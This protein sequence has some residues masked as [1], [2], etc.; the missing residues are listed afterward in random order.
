[1]RHRLPASFETNKHAL[2]CPPPSHPQLVKIWKVDGDRPR[3]V[4]AKDLQLG[5]LYDVAFCSDA[6]HLLAAGGNKGKVG[7]WDATD[8][9][10]VCEVLGLQRTE[11]P[12]GGSVVTSGMEVG[13]AAPHAHRETGARAWEAARRAEPHRARWQ[14]ELT[15]APRDRSPS[16]A[17]VPC[18]R[19]M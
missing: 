10:G 9:A 17:P 6:P 5:A 7:V 19:S 11:T 8:S 12:I 13:A 1:L 16:R 3:L 14:S 18:R 2:P 15:A 4:V